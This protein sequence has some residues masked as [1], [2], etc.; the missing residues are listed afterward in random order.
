MPRPL[1]SVISRLRRS[2]IQSQAVS[3]RNSARSSP[4][5]IVDVL[6]AGGMAQPGFRRSNRS[7]RELLEEL[8]L[9]GYV[10]K[11]AHLVGELDYRRR[12]QLGL[13]L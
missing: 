13:D 11:L 6:D 8:H 4:R 1:A 12:P 5:E 10:K 9:C 7:R 3:L 2:A